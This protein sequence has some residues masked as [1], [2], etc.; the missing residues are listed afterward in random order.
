MIF[1]LI[2]L[3]SFLLPQAEATPGDVVAKAVRD[4]RERKGYRVD[5]SS[6]ARP[7]KSDPL[8]KKGYAIVINPDILYLDYEGSGKQI[9]RLIRKG[10][11]A[12]R[13]HPVLEEWIDPLLYEG[14]ESD[15]GGI[16]DID[17][18][19]SEVLLHLPEVKKEGEERVADAPC[20][21]LAIAF[22]GTTLKEIVARQEIDAESVRWDDSAAEVRLWIGKEDGRIR[23]LTVEGTVLCERQAGATETIAYEAEA[24]I[25]AGDRG[26]DLSHV[27]EKVRK[28][29][30]IE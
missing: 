23:R 19:L 15:G 8:E 6:T 18:L 12:L 17:R 29:V 28:S 5:F 14:E 13:F 9:V 24:A 20:V 4:L 21:K 7:P 30:G 2:T 27:P 22:T 26:L 11:K 16:Y 10:Q 3:W 1:C 25:G